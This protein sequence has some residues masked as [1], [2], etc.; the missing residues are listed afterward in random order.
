MAN[1]VLAIENRGIYQVH[2]NAE[3]E[4]WS[5]VCAEAETVERISGLVGWLPYTSLHRVRTRY[6]DM[7]YFVEEE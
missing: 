5:D 6:G 7:M 2:P 1:A 3:P 4:C